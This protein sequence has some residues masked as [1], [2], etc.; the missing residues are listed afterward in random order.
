EPVVHEVGWPGKGRGQHHHAR[1]CDAAR[2]RGLHDRRD[3]AVDLFAGGAGG[4][5]SMAA[6]RSAR[7]VPRATVEPRSASTGTLEDAS[8]P[9]AIT[10]AIFA[11]RSDARTSGTDVSSG[12]AEV[13]SKKRA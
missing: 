13:R 7:N 4:C 11:V 2:A 12:R 1:R 8:T 6:N 3:H 5:A 10:V 9:K